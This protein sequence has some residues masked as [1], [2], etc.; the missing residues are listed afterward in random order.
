MKRTLLGSAAAGLALA[1]LA[2][3]AAPTASG[4]ASPMGASRTA[5]SSDAGALSCATPH[6]GCACEPEGQLVACGEVRGTTSAG[7]A[8]CHYGYRRCES[9]VWSAC[10]QLQDLTP[11]QGAAVV[12][13]VVPF[14]ADARRRGVLGDP[15]DPTARASRRRRSPMRVCSW[16]PATAAPARPASPCSPRPGSTSTRGSP[17][18]VPRADGARRRPRD[19]DPQ[20][21][22]RLLPLQLDER[23]AGV[24]RHARGADA[25]GDELGRGGHPEHGVRPRGASRTTRRGRTPRSRAPTPST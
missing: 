18:P 1:T 17:R 13:R 23:D 11:T 14:R 25:G 6:A 16:A 20:P 9:G 21:G 2:A 7:V 12:A 8:D 24:V 10:A 22:R 15:C 5:T 4:E 19:D 3:C